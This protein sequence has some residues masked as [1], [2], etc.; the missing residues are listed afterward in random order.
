[1]N[2]NFTIYRGNTAKGHHYVPSSYLRRFVDSEGFLNVWDRPRSQLRR[3]R[4]AEVMKI[5]YYYRQPWVPQGVDP[6]IMET[7]LGNDLE[8]KAKYAIDR[9]INDPAS[10]DDHDSATLLTYLEFQRIR[11]PRQAEMA[12]HLMREAILRL[13]PI[14]VSDSI[15]DGTYNYR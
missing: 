9:L 14:S 7:A 3:Q 4:P 10:L 13:A 6:N 5:R 1:M 2:A 12:K 15:S 11:V 8:G